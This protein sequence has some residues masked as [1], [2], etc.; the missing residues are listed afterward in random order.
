[1]NNLAI[2]KFYKDIINLVN[3]CNLPVGTAY[4]IVKD[5][6]H[7]LEQAYITVLKEEINEPDQQ[8]TEEIELYPDDLSEKGDN[9]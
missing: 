6:L 2:Q 8:V 5:V 9:I 1:M 7:D 4:F 3:N